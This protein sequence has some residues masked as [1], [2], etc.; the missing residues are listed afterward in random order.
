LEM[1]AAG[2]AAGAASANAVVAHSTHPTSG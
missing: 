1:A 2:L